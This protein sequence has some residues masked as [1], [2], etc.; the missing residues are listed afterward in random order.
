MRP[1]VPEVT[2]LAPLVKGG[3]QGKILSLSASEHSYSLPLV[4]GGLGRG[5]SQIQ[6]RLHRLHHNHER[7]APPH[8]P[9]NLCH[10]PQ[11]TRQIFKN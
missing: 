10:Y 5:S 8:Q 4:R 7:P 6:H 2:P 9:R 3:I 1:Q 11:T